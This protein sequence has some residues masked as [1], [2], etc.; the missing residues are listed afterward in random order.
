MSSHFDVDGGTRCEENP[1]TREHIF[2]CT[3]PVS[4]GREDI[5]Y[6]T[7][8]CTCSSRCTK[9][10]LMV[11]SVRAKAIA[12][13]SPAKSPRS[14]LISAFE[15]R[16]QSPQP[17][18]RLPH[19]LHNITLP[20]PHR[21]HYRNHIPQAGANVISARH[22]TAACEDSL[23]GTALCAPAQ[24]IHFDQTT[25]ANQISKHERRALLV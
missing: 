17:T 11:V 2:H 15:S 12:T 3:S 19:S 16:L 18:S 9:V 10:R 13:T 5:A 21:Y 7:A 8:T 1:T 25:S 20:L 23:S 14:A 22:R 6:G 4:R 24:H